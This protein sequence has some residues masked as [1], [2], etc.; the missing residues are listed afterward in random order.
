MLKLNGMTNPAVNYFVYNNGISTLERAIKER[1]F[2][3]SDGAGGF[4]FPPTTT[5]QVWKSET[6]AFTRQLSRYS[7]HVA[8]MSES[9]FL[10][11]YSGSRK[12]EVYR[13]AF[14]DNRNLGGVMRKHAYTSD[15]VK[16]EK[17]L[18]PVPRVIRP[19]HPRYNAPLGLF[20]RPIEHNLY[21]SIDKVFGFDTHGCKTVMKGLNMEQCAYHIHR[22]FSR[23]KN[24]VI[25]PIDAKRF[26]Q[27][28]TIPALEFEHSCYEQYNYDPFFKTLLGWQLVN[29]GFGRCKDGTLTYRVF[30]TR[31][32]GVINTASGNVVI[33]V[34]MIYSFMLSLGF[35]P[36]QYAVVDNGDDAA[37][38]I[39]TEHLDKIM[40]A[41][42]AYFLKLGYEMTIE[43]PVYEL[44]KFVFCQAQP[45]WDGTKWIMVRDPWKAMS[46]DAICLKYYESFKGYDS[47]LAAVAKGGLSLTGGIPIWQSYYKRLLMLSNGA[48]PLSG[49]PTQETGLRLMSKGIRRGYCT[50]D[51]S[52]RV[53]F[54]KAFGICPNNQIIFE[55]G[56]EQMVI[57]DTVAQE[58]H[59]FNPG[60]L[61]NLT[62]E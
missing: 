2:F 24:P 20:M 27:H 1:V 45:V 47:W 59:A 10:A 40:S 37:I 29:R 33:T 3:V 52:A 51:S 50:I 12:M 61:W 8:P 11:C 53:S 49:D 35:T 23:F 25:I 36:D 17:Q 31:T 39:E 7:H 5:S 34:A 19:G 6:A 57:G 38:I 26:D 9:K 13:K 44:E 48:T 58:Q 16:G 15:F 54:W 32:S 55:E 43:E 14:E 60:A 30:G 46:K 18:K 21:R 28:T 22:S 62:P 42:D 56:L 41:L 4:V